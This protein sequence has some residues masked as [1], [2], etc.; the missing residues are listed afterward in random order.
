MLN[1]QTYLGNGSVYISTFVHYWQFILPFSLALMFGS[2]FIP[3]FII[4]LTGF[5]IGFSFIYPYLL[6]ITYF[7]NMI[8]KNPSLAL[9]IQ[10]IIGIVSAAAFWGLFKILG[11][12]GGFLI[13]GFLGKTLFEVLLK[14]NVSLQQSIAKLP[15]SIQTFGWLIFIGFGVIGGIIVLKKTDEAIQFLSIVVGSALVSFYTIYGIE[16]LTKSGNILRILANSPK[17]GEIISLSK[18]EM[19]TFLIFTLVYIFI[20]YYLSAKALR[21]RENLREKNL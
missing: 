16:I 15:I 17:S 10:V 20:V 12:L 21:K 19:V 9:P 1:L 11:F 3:K 18:E 2:R 4:I 13:L 7:N 14:N 5:V 8:V 6:T